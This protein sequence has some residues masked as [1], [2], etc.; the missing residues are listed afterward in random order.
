MEIAQE[1]NQSA[2]DSVLRNG[3]DFVEKKLLKT[4]ARHFNRALYL[5]ANSSTQKLSEQLDAYYQKNQYE[6]VLTIGIL[7][8]KHHFEPVEL[9]NKMGNS[10]RKLK[11]YKMANEYFKRAIRKNKDH[12][13]SLY[14]FAAS[15][16]RLDCHD[17]HVNKLIYQAG[18]FKEVILPRTVT[19]T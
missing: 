17:D 6:A 10:A 15:L 7:I 13:P 18:N 11:N 5:N 1:E 12:K 9:L 19:R 4:A 14:Y 3:F 8:M 2:A 16:A